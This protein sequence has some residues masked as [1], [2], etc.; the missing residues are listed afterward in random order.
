MER[1]NAMNPNGSQKPSRPAKNIAF[2]I[3]VCAAVLAVG[4][5]SMSKLAS[6]KQPP[7]E[8]ERTERALRVEAMRVQPVNVEVAITGYGDVK[9]LN[10]VSIAP[11]VAGKVVRIHPRL[12]AGEIIPRD[13]VLFEIDARNYA[14]AL[15]E[16]RAAVSQYQNAILRLRKQ[17]AIDRERLETL[18][19][20][21]ELAK[22]EFGRI[23]LLYEK[24]RVGTRSAVDRA[25]QAYNSAADQVDLIEQK[26]T[27]YPI[28]IK[29]AQSSLAAAQA[30]LE[31]AEADYERCQVKAPFKGRIKSVALEEDQ[32]VSPGQAVMTLA[33]DSILEI[34]V[35]IDSR[36]ARRWLRF[37][38]VASGTEA[39]WFQEL[40]PVMCEIRW[41]EDTEGSV[42]LGRLDRVVKFDQQTR[43]VTVAVRIDAETRAQQAPTDL[44]I[45][46]G[47]FCAVSIPG[48]TLQHVFELPRRAVSFENKVYAAVNN[49]L[50]TLSVEVARTESG[51]AYIST[52]LKTGDTVIV[53]RLVDPLEGSLLE[54]TYQEDQESS[55]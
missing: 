11:E 38:N 3:I 43:T 17:Y 18:K 33:D 45:V 19:R 44:P 39:F 40:E 23:R 5:I 50:K 14:A 16:A 34:Q 1:S 29:E 36:D 42:W 46:E 26:V 22:N 4:V 6:L 51:V 10:V 15:K 27:L 20:N 24:D 52:G 25:E 37:K 9:A 13:E 55:S 21:Q 49:R 35:S 48:K 2:R 54:I 7:T 47:M 28:Q 30:R 32:Y 31:R 41:T 53:T 8:V 12:Q